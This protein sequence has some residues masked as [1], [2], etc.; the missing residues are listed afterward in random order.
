MCTTRF[1]NF[2]WNSWQYTHQAAWWGAHIRMVRVQNDSPECGLPDLQLLWS[3]Q[4]YGVR[5]WTFSTV[6]FPVYLFIYPV[7]WHQIQTLLS[8]ELISWLTRNTFLSTLYL[9]AVTH[10]YA[11][12]QTVC[13]TDLRSFRGSLGTVSCQLTFLLVQE[14]LVPAGA[15]CVIG[16][17]VSCLVCVN[18]VGS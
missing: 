6:Y 9:A 2:S 11:H 18:W 16:K 13:T 4:M 1:F 7:I 15:A 12:M 14:N 5:S 10:P 8:E 17:L 3:L